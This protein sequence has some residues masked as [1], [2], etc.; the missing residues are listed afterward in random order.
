M[1][2][3][4]APVLVRFAGFD[5]LGP[6]AERDPPDGELREAG[7]GAGREGGP[8]VGADTLRQTVLLEEPAEAA[9][10]ELEVETQHPLA[11]EQEAGVSVLHGE[12]EAEL[13]VPG[14]KLALEVRGPGAV[15]PRRNGEGRAGVVTAPAWLPR[16][17]AAVAHEDAVNGI[18]AGYGLD[19]GVVREQAP[20]LAGS[21]DI[22]LPRAVLAEFENPSNHEI[23]RG[24]RAGPGTVRAVLEP[25]QLLDLVSPDPFVPGGS[26]D[27]MPAAEL[28]V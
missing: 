28:G 11:G 22:A 2:A 27:A 19:G 1:H 16:F 8:V 24:M 20:D 4:M 18:A 7:D 15:G 5:E 23:G 9:H 10:R 12:R 13:T 6:D 26:A 21:P 3:F 14:P 17:D 25:F